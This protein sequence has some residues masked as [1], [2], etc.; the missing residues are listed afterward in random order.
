[1]ATRSPVKLK[2]CSVAPRQQESECLKVAEVI[3][4]PSKDV[5]QVLIELRVCQV[6]EQILGKQLEK[7]LDVQSLIPPQSG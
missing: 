4:G 7:S 6:C 2:E 3:A 1:M 5:G